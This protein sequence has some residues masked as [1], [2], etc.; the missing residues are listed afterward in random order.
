MDKG[1][2]RGNE[3]TRHL[4]PAAVGSAA[5]DAVS[6]TMGLALDTRLQLLHQSCAAVCPHPRL[7]LEGILIHLAPIW[8][9]QSGSVFQQGD[10]HHQ[11]FF[12]KVLSVRDRGKSDFDMGVL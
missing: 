8:F 12:V 2:N 10:F 5:L 9:F 4:L 1:G 3:Q 11:I 6:R 7:S